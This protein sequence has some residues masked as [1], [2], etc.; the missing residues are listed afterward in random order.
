VVVRVV[1]AKAVVFVSVVENG[2]VAAMAMALRARGVCSD[3]AHAGSVGE[4]A[5]AREWGI[6]RSAPA[7]AQLVSKR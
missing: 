2:G 3:G 4:V 1:V 5:D 7:K 6:R